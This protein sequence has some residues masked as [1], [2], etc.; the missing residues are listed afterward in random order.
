MKKLCYLQM[1]FMRAIVL[2]SCMAAF[3][4]ANAQGG[5]ILK[6]TEKSMTLGEAF[7]TIEKQ[8]GMAIAYNE[9]HLDL[10]RV[11]STDM[12]TATLT[13]ALDRILKGFDVS[14]QILDRQILIIKK[15]VATSKTHRYHGTVTDD[16]RQP[17][18]GA[19]VVVKGS[20][21]G[22][23][24]SIDGTF[25]IA[26][27][28][29]SVLSVS[30]LGYET[31]E[32]RLGSRQQLVITL[33]EDSQKLDDVVVVGYGTFQKRD[34]S[35][36]IGT[37]KPQELNA[38]EVLS[39]D[40]MLQGRIPG[41][42]ITSASGVPGSQN[43]VSIRGIGSLTASNEPL[44]VID[45]VPLRNSSGDAGVWGSQSMNGLA[46]FNPDDIESVEVLKDAASAAIYGS[47]AT[48]G[49]ILIT[50]K[51]GRKG[52]ARVSVNA[53]TSFS[54]LPRT[55]RLTMAD[56]DLYLEVMNEA[57]DNWNLQSGESVSRME[58]PFPGKKRVQWLD[59]ILRTATSYN[60]GASV[61]GGTDAF[62]YYVSGNYKRNEGVFIGNTLTK[63][64]FN[65]KINGNVRKWLDIGM[66]L[67]AGYTDNNRVPTGYNIGTNL[68]PRALE[69]Y[70]WDGP[71]NPDGSYT[72]NSNPLLN[73]NVVQAL[74]EEDV[75]V[76]NWRLLGNAYLQFNIVKGLTFKT[77]LG[78]DFLHTEEHIYYTKDHT[79]GRNLGVLI[80]GR[81]TMT[82][83]LT[84][85][86]LNYTGTFA[87]KLKLNAMLG[88]SYQI[89][90]SSNASQTGVGF[91][92]PSFD[93]N[94][95]AAEYEGITSGLSAYEL[96]SY[97][98]RANLNWDDR[99]LLTVA[100]R[101]DG[102][103]KFAPH[104]RYG[105][106][107]SISAGWNIS[108][109]K[110]WNE[111]SIGLKIRASYGATGNQTGID[112]YAWLARAG[113]GY[114]YN[115]NNG[116]GLSSAGNPDL[117][118][119][120]ADQT[121]V[122][123]DLSF[124]RGA[125]TFTADAFV[126]DT[127][128]LLY[129]KPTAATTGFTTYTCNIGSM[130]NQG[131][132]FS[133][134]GTLASKSGFTWRSDFNM[135]FIRN[136]LTALLDD[137]EILMPDVYHA[138]KVGKEVGS[139]YMI[140]AVGIYQYDEEV[141]EKLYAK[142]V[143]A[144]DVIYED[145]NGDGDIDTT[146][147]RQFVGSAN[148]KFTGGFNNTFTYKGIDLSIFLTFSYGNKL[149]EAWTGGYRM[150]NGVWTMLESVAKSRW[151]GP[152]TSNTTPRAIWGQTW[153]STMF[154]PN[155][156]FLHDASYLRCR[157][158]QVG[159]TFP[160]KWMTAAGIQSLRVYFSAD[161]LFIITPYPLL[162]PEVNVSLNATTLG[163]DFLYPSQPRTF[164]VGLN[165]KF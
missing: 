56:S 159:Y 8:S 22:T 144:G 54:M 164:S 32:E 60:V 115:G 101:T 111:D 112:S 136:K 143:R 91:P 105:W 155:S 35:S 151:T 92:S 59:L 58:N 140:K 132:E 23:T 45:G 116:L 70:P 39:V 124:F 157:A 128:N 43:R 154:T 26:A 103:S 24:T 98:A 36:A 137:N 78:G 33:K 77:S 147:D 141:P 64:N 1:L 6:F 73:H 25:D 27:A 17:L 12:G 114:N 62:N 139:F 30:F 150:G 138:L 108:E 40:E 85:H 48:N 53:S 90:Q 14:Y 76:R 63:Y 118:W 106:F 149:Y 162:D 71:Y 125:L 127:K 95:S 146:N 2:I 121:D 57:I 19:A 13:E 5:G 83:L 21:T 55:D 9:V 100:V 120:K 52:K 68:I 81:R 18:I 88:Y 148:P 50:T 102:S 80:D 41:V 161:N 61:S 134:S 28:E 82:N 117:K 16:S 119:E 15:P 113:G 34:V 130:R 109:E 87:E 129:Q 79:Y 75:Y 72:T 145:V 3:S 97:F 104:N 31:Y 93:V 153:N 11:V 84:E 126:K 65:S 156:R 10:N 37:Y 49:V 133:I 160:K 38:R 96:Q 163:Y 44:Y 152:G 165:I 158:L 99:Y 69:Q 46:D 67:T 142:G 51:S 131:L 135:A 122:G 86:V 74:N 47:R 123:I 110:F 4:V 107:P 20:T 7:A 29:G 94:S 89:Y 66:N 42:S